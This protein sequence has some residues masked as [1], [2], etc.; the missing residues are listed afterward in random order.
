MTLQL[1]S[2]MR[3]DHHAATNAPTWQAALTQRNRRLPDFKRLSGVIVWDEEWPLT[4]SMKVKR[5]VL[6]ERIRAAHTRADVRALEA[7]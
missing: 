4:A 5:G 3:N 1:Q 2:C 6:A 7:R